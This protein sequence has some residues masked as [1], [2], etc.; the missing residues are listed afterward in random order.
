MLSSPTATAGH[1]A[2]CS[3]SGYRRWVSSRRRTGRI[4][5]S[6][7]TTRIADK[8]LPD[9]A[10]PDGILTAMRD[11]A[12]QILGARFGGTALVLWAPHEEPWVDYSLA[13]QTDA[14][15]ELTR[16]TAI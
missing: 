7:S 13:T 5:G 11:R 10:Y 3:R 14:A 2:S 15:A 4:S 12:V 1:R 16:L 8:I 6:P 9:A